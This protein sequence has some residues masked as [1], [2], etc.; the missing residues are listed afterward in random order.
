M[1]GT[2]ESNDKLKLRLKLNLMLE[3]S[4]A[5][6][7]TSLS[8]PKGKGI[9]TYHLQVQRAPVP[10]LMQ[11]FVMMIW[12]LWKE[13]CCHNASNNRSLAMVSIPSISIHIITTLDH[14]LCPS[15]GSF[16]L[17]ICNNLLS[18]VEKLHRNF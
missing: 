5:T 1:L 12:I 10:C 13:I 4:L 9:P 18:F 6:T 11:S 8:S 16:L 2:L 17:V 3:L 7:F 14:C 15:I